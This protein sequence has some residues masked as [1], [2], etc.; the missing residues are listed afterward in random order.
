MD[1]PTDLLRGDAYADSWSIARRR[2]MLRLQDIMTRDVVTV[3]PEL[4]LRD[5][6]E[7]LT[8][9][10][11]SGAPVVVG[12]IV[13]GVISLN[14]VAEV[15]AAAPG[16]P[17]HRAEVPDWGE[18]QDPLEWIDEEE[19]PA[20]YFAQLWEDSAVDVVARMEQV[21]GGRWNAL[22]ELTVSDAMNARVV[23]LP[24]DTPVERAAEVMRRA[25][26]HRLLVMEGGRLLGLVSTTDV[27]GAVADHRF[28]R[29][30]YVFGNTAADRGD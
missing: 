19:P 29:Q 7:L 11:I 2:S 13:V 17:T 4:S 3:S 25:G 28:G 18:Y 26:V 14:D 24:P 1:C 9:R 15:A 30:V 23:A 5:T 22:E 12:G 16:A 20:A 8:T 27:T 10:H 21:A 6:M